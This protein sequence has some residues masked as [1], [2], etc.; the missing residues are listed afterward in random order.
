MQTPEETIQF[1]KDYMTNPR[2]KTDKDIEKNM[3]LSEAT[4]QKAE[5]FAESKDEYLKHEYAANA[6]KA[7]HNIS[8]LHGYQSTHHWIKQYEKLAQKEG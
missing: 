4:R 6:A 8:N 3:D 2:S 5:S 7:L 1:I